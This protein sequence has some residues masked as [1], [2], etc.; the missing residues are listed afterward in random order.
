MQ[1]HSQDLDVLPPGWVLRTRDRAREWLAVSILS[2][3]SNVDM[4]KVEVHT[5]DATA[6][7]VRRA[8]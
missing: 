3:M 6:V 7:Y 5:K 4:L 8:P 1:Y 2:R